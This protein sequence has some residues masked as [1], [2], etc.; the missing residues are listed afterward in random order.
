ML[1]PLEGNMTDISRSER[2]LTKQKRI[3]ELA[4]QNLK[5]GLTSLNQFI[6]LEWM[7]E[8]WQFTRKDGAL[9]MDELTA[10]DFEMELGTNLEILLHEAKSGNYH[11]PY[12][13]RVHIPKGNGE[14]RP[15]G[16]TTIGDKVLQRAI[17]MLLEPIY[18]QIFTE[19]SFG[20]RPKR[21]AH[22][23]CDELK[24]A[25][26]EFYGGYVLEVDIKSYF[27]TIDKSLLREFLQKRITDGVILRLIAKW[28]NTGIV[29]RGVVHFQD[30]GTAQ[31]GVVSPILSN[32]YLHYVLDEWFETEVMKRLISKSRLIR[33]CDDFCIYF[34]VKADAERVYKV[35]EKRFAKFGLTLHPD[36]TRIINF[37]S[38]YKTQT[39]QD[40]K[41]TQTFG[42]LG[43]TFYWSLSRQGNWVIKQKTARK[44]FN[45]SLIAFTRWCRE[46]RHGKLSWQLDRVV[47]KLRGHKNYFGVKGN[48]R[49]VGTFQYFALKIWR[50]WLSRRSNKG[51][52]TLEKMSMIIKN[53]TYFRTQK[54]L[55]TVSKPNI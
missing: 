13:K 19:N 50:K 2:V 5:Q 47:A 51:Y 36:K 26:W 20:F 30:K 39:K 54:I 7:M 38:P 15:I 55:Q 33:F 6:D 16:I 34:H 41:K 4:K 17:V 46:N 23:A 37:R 10:C 31:G 44:K 42:F 49:M 52:V 35:L 12:I 14:T 1:E 40:K 53:H 8:A 28:L 9:G 22:Q 29:E 18:E 24:K 3:A 32:I 11:A 43:F 45:K 48:S 27:D 21:N 25:A